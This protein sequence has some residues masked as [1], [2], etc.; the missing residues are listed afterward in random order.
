M[1]M[2]EGKEKVAPEIDLIIDKAWL[3]QNEFAVNL[4][5]S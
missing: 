4:E 5:Y 1:E 2:K 3:N